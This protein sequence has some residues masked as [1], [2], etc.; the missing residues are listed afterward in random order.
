MDSYGSSRKPKAYLIY[1]YSLFG[2][3]SV[4]KFKEKIREEYEVLDPFEEVG[5][6]VE[7]KIAEKDIELMQKC[8]VVIAF[9][10]IEGLQSGIEIGLAL[11]LKKKLIVYVS[12]RLK[13]PFFNWLVTQ[14][15]EVI[16]F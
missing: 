4:R 1:P 15:V 11:S 12:H 16:T 10:P 2:S 5:I 9:L 14:G 6:G 8:D 13:G 7:P 3:S